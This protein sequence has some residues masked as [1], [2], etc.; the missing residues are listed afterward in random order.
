MTTATIA[1]LNVYPVKACRGIALERAAVT[2]RGLATGTAGDREW[3]VVD[4]NGRFVSQREQPRLA[5]VGVASDAR[6]LALSA[7]AMPTLEVAE[8]DAARAP[9]RN[10]VVWQ[11]TVAAIDAGD[12]AAQWLCAYL[13]MPAR[14][15]RFAPEHVRACNPQFVGASGA[16]TAFADGYPA[17]VIGEASLDDLN[18]RLV[19]NGHRALPMNRFRPNVVIAGLEPFDEDHIDTI[20]IDGVTLKLV[21]PCVRCRVTTTD[22]QS[23]AVGDEPLMTLATYRMDE[24]YDGVTFGMNAIVVA[25]DSRTLEVG[26]NAQVEYR[27]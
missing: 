13:E 7:P 3:M 27:F 4:A 1:A 25:G 5:L 2:V 24:R 8:P 21:K 15:V 20:A 11:S 12:R 22:Q 6:G 9:R 26:A 23:A 10:V 16:H 14:L 18:A 17:L 19:A